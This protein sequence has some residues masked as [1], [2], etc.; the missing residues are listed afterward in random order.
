[1]IYLTSLL[2]YAPASLLSYFLSL[3]SNGRIEIANTTGTIWRGEGIPVLHQRSG[4][5]ITLS[6]LSWI[7][8][9]PTLLTGK[10]STQLTW[11]NSAQSA[12]MSVIASP[13]LIEIRHAYLPLPAM[14]LDEASDFLKPAQ[15][16][17]QTV[18]QSDSLL[19]SRQG[20]QGSATAEWLNASS[21]LSDISPLGNYHF[22]FTFT[23]NSVDIQLKTTSGALVLAGQ[24]KMTTAGLDF[25]GSAQA[26]K[27]KEVALR[28][29]LNHLGPE[30]RPGVNTFSLVP[31]GH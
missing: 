16:R 4:S 6:P 19:I 28:E 13:N 12:P 25:K 27:G 8:S 18:L 26:E 17:G 20:V 2:A 5:L 22:D 3:A 30:E 29:L 31:S 15:L 1:M 14:V 24:G 10:L 23:H 21:L 9:A 7:I 11:S